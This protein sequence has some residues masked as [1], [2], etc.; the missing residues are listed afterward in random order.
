MSV[1]SSSDTEIEAALTSLDSS[2][3]GE[4]IAT[5]DEPICVSDIEDDMPHA[6]DG[7]EHWQTRCD[8]FSLIYEELKFNHDIIFKFSSEAFADT[9]VTQMVHAQY[10]IDT[11]LKEDNSG[12]FQVFA[13][14]HSKPEVSPFFLV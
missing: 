10:V 9:L 6:K 5:D 2:S 14:S 7:I 8:R 4:P 11:L 1:T 13:E 12:S 3:A